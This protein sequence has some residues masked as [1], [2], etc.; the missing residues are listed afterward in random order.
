MPISA[1][2]VLSCCTGCAL[3]C[4]GG[5]PAFV[6]DFWCLYGIP[7]GGLYNTTEVSKGI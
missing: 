7:T 6:Y 3:G 1:K 5:T 2:Y 4:E